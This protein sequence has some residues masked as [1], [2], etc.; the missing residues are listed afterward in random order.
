MGL[1]KLSPDA[2]HLRRI[3]RA[4][5]A[6]ECSRAE[7]RA[8]R[9]EIIETFSRQ[10]SVEDTQRRDDTLRTL[11]ARS[12]PDAAND[13]GRTSAPATDGAI[14]SA[15]PPARRRTPRPVVAIVLLS[16][17]TLLL[18]TVALAADPLIPAVRDRDPNPATSARLAVATVRLP[19]L[20]RADGTPLYAG[21][22]AAV[23]DEQIRAALG[24]VQ[25]RHALGPHG[26]SGP[27]LAEL[28]RLLDAFGVHE[29]QAALSAQESQALLD[30]IAT[31]KQRRG[32][33]VRE[34]EEVAE[35]VER[36]VR[37][38]GYFLA[39]V[40]L[41]QQQVRGG[42]VELALLPGT[43]GAVTINGPME[44]LIRQELADLSGEVLTRG[45]LETRLYRISQLPGLRT[46]ATLAPGT[47]VGATALTIDVLEERTFAGLVQL[48]NYGL[49]DTGEERL[50]ARLSWR[51]PWQRGDVLE[52]GLRTSFDPLDQQQ[53]WARYELPLRRS[54]Y[55]LEFFAGNNR[56]DFN[57]VRGVDADLDGDSRLLE[58]G[59]RRSYW[60]T[61]RSSAHA[62]LNVGYHDLSWREFES[63]RF[64]FANLA[65]TGHRLWDR[66]RLSLNGGAAAELGHVFSGTAPGQDRSY[67]RL[68][69]W[70][71]LWKPVSLP[72]FA[73][74]QKFAVRWQAQYAGSELPATRALSMGGPYFGRGFERTQFLADRAVSLALE[75]R[76]PMRL[77]ELYGFFDSAYGNGENNR[78]EPWGH[79]TSLGVGWDADWAGAF[80]SRLS[81]ALPITGDGSP[82]IDAPGP[83]LYWKLQYAY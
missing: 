50:G 77:G 46:Q 51:N 24:E 57:S 73:G 80:T 39:E 36:Y 13:P 60:Q 32:I 21:L 22:D 37:S 7:Y 6:G 27:E 38:Q 54:P 64:S 3:A 52:L 48:D 30:L 42:V 45:Q 15:Q 44:P 41:P 62:R 8:A 58:A 72:L 14:G 82:P 26:F 56:Y 47:E 76:F 34:L 11:D 29:P 17:L 2:V 71:R 55:R 70:G 40:Y 43:L 20:S 68:A 18:A 10:P 33:S 35:A 69:L 19:G 61:R 78:D 4:Y 23:I 5:H 83:Q 9:A 65:F 63:Q 75:L 67:Y 74:E 1:L 31:Q 25:A 16:L 79:L 59:L 81:L 53:I 28:G 49:D 12:W 66:T